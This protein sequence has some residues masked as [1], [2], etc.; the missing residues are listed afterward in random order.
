MDR[1]APK[2][3]LTDAELDARFPEFGKW[4][5]EIATLRAN[6]RKNQSAV[7]PNYI[8]AAWDV[9]KTP[10]P[11]VRPWSNAGTAASSKARILPLTQAR[12]DSLARSD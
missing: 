11:T 3:G 2:D 7:E 12:M 4:K 9:S 10:S 8:E 5:A 6:R 1:T